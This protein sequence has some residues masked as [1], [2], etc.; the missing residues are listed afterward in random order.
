MA[1]QPPVLLLTRS[2]VASLLTLD[3]HIQAVE[4]AF[5]KHAANQALKPELMHV[6]APDGEFHIKAGGVPPYFALKS[7]GGFFRNSAKFGLPNIQGLILLCDAQNGSPLAVMDSTEIT[8]KR[9]GAATAVAARHLARPE[10]ACAVICGCGNQGKIQLESL[11]RVLPL[12]KAFA[13][14][15][16]PERAQA[17]AA[18]MSARLSIEVVPAAELDAALAGSDVCATCTPAKGW[19]LASQ[20]VPDGMFIAAVGADSPDKQELEPALTARAK[21][22]TD[23]LDQCARVGELHHAIAAGLMTRQSAHAQ[24]GEVIAGTRPGRESAAE[25]IVF[26]STGTA[27]QDVA[28]AAAAYQRAMELGKGVPFDVFS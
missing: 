26:D 25:T 22:V 11:A 20:D 5:R 9:T 13:W 10:S 1:K 6:D 8:R 23:I 15:R 14:S 21:L 19:F 27:L 28:S 17:F 16:R 2:D 18:E 3:D 24:L 12:R 4:D 7:N